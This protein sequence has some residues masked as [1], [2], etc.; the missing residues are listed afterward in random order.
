MDNQPLFSERH[1]QLTPLWKRIWQWFFRSKMTESNL[2]TII[3]ETFK[4]GYETIYT[5]K[6]EEHFNEVI[7]HSKE[8]CYCHGSL[9]KKFNAVHRYDCPL[10]KK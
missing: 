1:K 8:G 9:P 7:E 5:K 3:V 10:F 2:E 6:S 4:N